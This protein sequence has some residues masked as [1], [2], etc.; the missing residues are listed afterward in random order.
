MLR[1]PLPLRA[2]CLFYIALS[3]SVRAADPQAPLSSQKR[4]GYKTGDLLPVSC[5]NRTIDTGEHITDSHGNLQYIPFPTC[6]ETSQPLA[7][8]YNTPLTQTCTIDSLPDELY[9]LIEFF[10]HS[11]VPLTCRV[12]TY[13][14]DAT[15]ALESGTSAGVGSTSDVD[16]WTPFT[17][18]VQG[19]LQTSHLHLHTNINVLF[20]TSIDDPVSSSTTTSKKPKNAPAAPQSHLIASAAYSVPNPSLSSPKEGVKII[21]YEPLEFT[22]NV[23]WVDG[24]VLP[25]MVG[26]PVLGVRDH[27][28]GFSLLS[29]MGLAA[30]AGFGALGMLLWERKKSGRTRGNGLLGGNV[31]AGGGVGGM[32][33]GGVVRSSGYGGYGGYGGYSN[34]IGKRD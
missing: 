19:T 5:L 28:V 3:A 29:L 8:P 7:F 18:A 1:L 34:G 32:G 17:I 2:L 24:D 23:A 6:N 10:V 33:N 26:R 12:P 27:S 25:G 11:D 9:H 15:D 16:T 21:R 31:G 30:A 4:R 13:P 14:L 22:F 20:H